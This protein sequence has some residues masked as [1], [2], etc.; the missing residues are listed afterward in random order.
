MLT[1]NNATCESI[2]IRNGDCVKIMFLGVLAAAIGRPTANT[3]TATASSSS[4]SEC[5]QWYSRFAELTSDL[6]GDKI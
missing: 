2:G 6:H 1:D 5:E 4:A 3:A